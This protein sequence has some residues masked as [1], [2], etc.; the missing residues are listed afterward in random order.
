VTRDE[1]TSAPVLVGRGLV[2][3]PPR[4]TDR[5]DRLAIGRN[6]EYVRLDGGNTRDLAP[7]TEDDVAQWYARIAG[8]QYGWVIDVGG[9]GVGSTRLKNFDAENRSAELAIGIFDPALWNRG[10]GTTTTRLVLRFAFDTLSL[11]R[12]ALIVLDE[13]VRAQAAYAKCGFTREGVLRDTVLI[14]G[15]W[16]S[17]IAMSILEDE[18]RRLAVTWEF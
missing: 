14:D 7:L 16:H 9:R 8:A 13:N 11:H 1:T 6:A 2:L 3:R 4:P 15:A 18:Y 5:A 10:L 17:D 12:V